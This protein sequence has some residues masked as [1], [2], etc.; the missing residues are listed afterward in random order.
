M[1]QLNLY[2]LRVRRHQPARG[3]GK[4]LLVEGIAENGLEYALKRQAEGLMVPGTEAICYRLA[5]ACGIATP[6]EAMLIDL[7]G[8]A[9]FGSRIEGG[10]FET[11]TLEPE[12]RIQEFQACAGRLSACFALDLLVGNEDRHFGNFL[13]RRRADGLLAI[14][15]IDYNRAFWLSG[16][17]PALSSL[18]QTMTL[19][20]LEML[21]A[22]GLWRPVDALTTLGTASTI[23]VQ[24]LTDWISALPAQWIPEAQR[25]QLLDWWGSPAFFAHVSACTQHCR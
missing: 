17:P 6:A 19:T 18:R 10:L 15:A 11:E 7:D 14:L 21:R 8:A 9:V 20:G 12:A 3:K 25:Q 22:L 1:S 2:S 13:Y 4:S 23:R 16:W 5:Q 24:D